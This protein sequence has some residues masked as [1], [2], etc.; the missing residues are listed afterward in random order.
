MAAGVARA[1]FDELCARA[2]GASDYLALARVCHTLVLD[3]V[4]VMD[5]A[6]RNEAKRFILLIDTLYDYM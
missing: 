5:E 1:G 3:H 2:Y 6:R 4:P